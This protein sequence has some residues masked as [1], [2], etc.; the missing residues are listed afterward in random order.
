MEPC[1][2]HNK[3]IRLFPFDLLILMTHGDKYPDSE[4]SFSIVEN[5]GSDFR[6]EKSV[7]GL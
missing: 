7:L 6:E 5:Q 4:T 1:L 2:A 3:I